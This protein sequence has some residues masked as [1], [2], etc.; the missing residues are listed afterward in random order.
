MYADKYQLMKF[1]FIFLILMGCLFNAKSASAHPYIS[2]LG[3][4][5]EGFENAADWTLSG[6]GATTENDTIDFIGGTQSIKVDAVNGNVTTITKSVSWDLSSGDVFSIWLYIPDTTNLKD[7]TMYISSASDFSSYFLKNINVRPQGWSQFFIKKS[8]F[9]NS[10]GESWSNP[11]IKFRLRVTPNTGTNTTIYYD[12]FRYGIVGRPKVILRFDDGSKSL[13]DKAYPIMAANNQ[14]GI[15]FVVADHIGYSSNYMTLTDLKTLQSA[16]WDIGNHT[17]NHINL[18]EASGVNMIASINN[19]YDWLVANGFGNTAKYFCYP[20][21]SYNDAV[22]AEVK[23]KH[24]LATGGSMNGHFNINDVWDS[25]NLRYL[26]NAYPTTV[27]T[28]ETAIDNAITLGIPLVLIFHNIVDSDATGENYLTEN[29]YLISDYLKTKQ[30]AGLLDVIT[31]SDYYNA[32]RPYAVGTNNIDIGAGATIYADGRFENTGTASGN[33]A[34][35][36]ITP[37][38]GFGTSDWF[39]YMDIS[40]DT[41]DTT[42][43]K[44][45]QWT[46]TSTSGD[47]LTHA[48][49]T[50]N[51]IGDLGPNTY[52]QFKLDGTASTTAI[53]NNSQCANGI[54]LSDTDGNLSFTYVGG[55]ST[56]TFA[57]TKDTTAPASFTLT[58]PANNDGISKGGTLS[59][60]ASS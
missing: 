60:T 48:T 4:V 12:E 52:Y 2:N 49:S 36:S 56:H 37:I 58:A 33:T 9:T 57:L 51:T 43:N 7:V 16:G 40:I 35:L 46:A 44:N 6:T 42:G 38:G 11:M 23:K 31:F 55:Y 19:G 13:I 5:I 29:F 26:I 10:A 50:I 30:D 22:I 3:T 34:S 1:F 28:A 24:I 14:K 25:L 45:K 8:D 15:A 53:I 41:W 18:V 47:F 17:S 21:T 27:L 59:W 39:Q 54:C 20:F 32:L